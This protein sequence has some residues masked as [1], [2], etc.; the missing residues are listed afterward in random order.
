MLRVG[1]GAGEDAGGEEA[2]EIRRGTWPEETL[3]FGE[4][5]EANKGG[6]TEGG[7]DGRWM[8]LTDWPPRGVSAPCRPAVLPV[9]WPPGHSPRSGLLAWCLTTAKHV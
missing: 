9:P 3:G 4:G 1:E 6:K 5:E 7:D 2:R 8:Y